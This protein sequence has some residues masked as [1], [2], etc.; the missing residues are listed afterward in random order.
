MSGPNANTTNAVTADAAGQLQLTVPLGPANPFQQDTPQG[1]ATRK[2]Y[3]THV[4]V[5]SA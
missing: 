2:D 1:D 5:A 3:A 4:T